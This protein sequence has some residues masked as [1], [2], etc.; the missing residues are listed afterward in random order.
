[1]E[2]TFNYEEARENLVKLCGKWNDQRINRQLEEAETTQKAIE[3]ALNDYNSHRRDDV[4]IECR[5]AEN[6][7]FEG[8]KLFT[9]PVLKVKDV[10]DKESESITKEVVDATKRIDLKALHKFCSGRKVSYDTSWYAMAQNLNMHMTV[11]VADML[12]DTETKNAI[13]KNG[14]YAMSSLAKSIDFGK[15]P[16]SNT[17]TLKTYTRMVQAMIGEEYKVTSKHVRYLDAVYVSDDKNS[18]NKVKAPNHNTFVMYLQKVCHC[19]I[20][21][22]PFGVDYKKAKD[23]K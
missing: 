18:E 20:L 3:D 15:T 12:G 14:T 19:L 6:P 7:I 22:I 9:Y 5:S 11:R 10:K 4:F 2:N 13:L 17:N 23:A 21:D 16:L 8:C 1:M